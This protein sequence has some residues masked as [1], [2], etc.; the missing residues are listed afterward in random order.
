MNRTA[1][2]RSILTHNVS[3]GI[4]G[5]CLHDSGLPLRGLVGHLDSLET[6]LQLAHLMSGVREALAGLV[7]PT[8]ELTKLTLI[9]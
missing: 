2:R 9:I 4:S 5:R 3:L 1:R 6:T 8:D 7:Y